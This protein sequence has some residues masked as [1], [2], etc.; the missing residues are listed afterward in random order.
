MRSSHISLTCESSVPVRCYLQAQGRL[1]LQQAPVLQEEM[2][3]LLTQ[4]L[5]LHLQAFQVLLPKQE[6]EEEKEA[7][8]K[9]YVSILTVK[10]IG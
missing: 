4:L 3:Y 7:V 10:H 1:H 6:V 8:K 9:R 2:I 5:F